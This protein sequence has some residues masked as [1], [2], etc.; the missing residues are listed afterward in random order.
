MHPVAVG[1]RHGPEPRPFDGEVLQDDV[2]RFPDHNGPHPFTV[3]VHG[4]AQTALDVIGIHPA[5]ACRITPELVPPVL[6]VA[7]NDTLAGDADI[8][9]LIDVD[10]RRRPD[11]LDVGNPRGQP[12]I[13][14]VVL[15]RLQR[16]AFIEPQL[17]I[18]FDE[19]RPRPIGARRECHHTASRPVRRI[20]GGLDRLGVDGLA[21][22]FHAVVFGLKD[23]IRNLRKSGVVEDRL[24]LLHR[25]GRT[26]GHAVRPPA[27]GAG[28]PLPA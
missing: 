5:R 11:H 20:D 9:L 16:H 2:T 18:A 8:L 13:M 24:R 19:N 28:D 25:P 12:R 14:A 3:I 10:Q 26:G 1:Q 6:T 22:G 21:V 4:P 23:A 7:V 17:H 27:R 15:H